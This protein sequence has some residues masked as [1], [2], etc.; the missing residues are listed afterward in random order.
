MRKSVSCGGFLLLGRVRPPHPRRHPCWATDG[1][2]SRDCHTMVGE[3]GSVLSPRRHNADS[4]ASLHPILVVSSYV[5]VAPSSSLLVDGEEI[6]L[7]L[8]QYTTSMMVYYSFL[9]LVRGSVDDVCLVCSCLTRKY[10][11]TRRMLIGCEG[12]YEYQ[13]Q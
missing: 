6:I 12:K 10:G 3:A 8:V 9:L 1:M 11:V 4:P 7:F 13:D 5:A 2:R